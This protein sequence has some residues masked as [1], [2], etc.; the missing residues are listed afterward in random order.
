MKVTGVNGQNVTQ[1]TANTT[2]FGAHGTL[3]INENGVYSYT[4]TSPETGNSAPD[5]FTYVVTDSHGNTSTSTLSFAIVDDVPQ[6]TGGNGSSA[7]VFDTSVFDAP[8]IA[9]SGGVNY[10]SGAD[11]FSS[12]TAVAVSGLSTMDGIAVTYSGN[13]AIGRIGSTVVFTLTLSEPSA[14]GAFNGSYTFDLLQPFPET[15]SSAANVGVFSSSSDTLRVNSNSTKI[16]TVSGETNSSSETVGTVT[17]GVSNVGNGIDL[18]VHHN[19]SSQTDFQTHDS[20]TFTFLNSPDVANFTF[21]NYTSG[22]SDEFNFTVIYANNTEITGSF[23]PSQFAS[24][25]KEWSS[26]LAGQAIT[27]ITFTDSNGNDKGGIDLQSTQT[28]TSSSQALSFG[29]TTTDGDGSTATGTINV[30]VDGPESSLLVNYD[31]ASSDPLQQFSGISYHEVTDAGASPGNS[32]YQLIGDSANDIFIATN[33]GDTMQAHSATSGNNIFEIANLGNNIS[34]NELITNF[35]S[36]NDVIDLTQL[37]NNV[38]IGANLSN[39]V[40]YLSSSSG[41]GSQA[42]ELLI[43]ETGG[44]FGTN[45]TGTVL[46]VATIDTN[47]PTSQTPAVHPT[48]AS[49]ST[50]PILIAYQD[51]THLVHSLHGHTG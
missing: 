9:T 25:A 19:S 24:A 10:V 22:H 7:T 33:V 17:S 43:N 48:A 47:V 1:S 51:S 3:T 40:E 31:T 41:T 46:T 5:R 34:P 2:I 44:G 39:Y 11:G 50:S 13:E 12:T 32:P 14:N 20:M 38:P 36:M 29:V 18:G 28:E 8:N 49:G 23:D 37:L 42:G 35:N 45:H 15:P 27:S 30:T 21:S 16:A 6:I 26:P 4:L